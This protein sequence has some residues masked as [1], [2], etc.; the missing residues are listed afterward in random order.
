MTKILHILDHSIPTLD[1]YAVRSL[2][3]VNYQRQLGL[4]P[5][6]MTSS[7]HESRGE[8]ESERFD[9]V[10]YFRTKRE[11]EVRLPFLREIQRIGRFARRIEE[12]IVREGPDLLH[13]HSPCLWAYA[14]LRA[15]KRFGIPVVYEIRGFW[16]DAAVDLGKTNSSSLRYVASKHL[17]TR[18]CRKVAAVTTIAEHLRGDLVLRGIDPK[19]IWLAPNGVD[20]ER[21]KPLDC[22]IDLKQRSFGSDRILIA[23]IGSLFAWEGVEDLV[24]AAP[25]IVRQCKD[26][27][28]VIVGGGDKESAIRTLIKSTNAEDLVTVVGQVRHA[29]VERYYSIMDVLVYPRIRTRN[30]ELC[31]PLKPLEAM[32]MEKAVLASD[33]GGLTELLVNGTA[34][35]FRAGDPSDLAAKCAQLVLSPE[36][37]RQ[38]GCNARKHVLACRNWKTIVEDY[39]QVYEFAMAKHGVPDR[40]SLLTTRV[41]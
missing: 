12:V 35:Q 5:I 16:E 20:A 32:A 13:A 10:R 4:D 23:F 30:T 1:G 27:H 31:T 26:A 21:F 29:E 11:K 28:I 6:V 3:I 39:A 14:A 15:A 8:S 19:K 37:R 2:N 25:L 7:Q 22:D 18:V 9:G 33:V 34:L 41:G 36:L 40:Q 17:E 24:R 38:L